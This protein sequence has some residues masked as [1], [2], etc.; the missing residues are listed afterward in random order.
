[1]TGGAHYTSVSDA[2]H[3]IIK[4]DGPATFFAGTSSRLLHKIPANGL[5]FLFYEAFRFMLGAV[6]KRSQQ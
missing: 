3:R 5:F 2:V 6:D 4:E 1:M